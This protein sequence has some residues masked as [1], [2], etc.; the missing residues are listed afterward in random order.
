MTYKATSVS[1]WDTV[2]QC[3]PNIKVLACAT[4]P[5][6]TTS[7]TQLSASIHVI[8]INESEPHILRKQNLSTGGHRIDGRVIGTYPRSI[9][10]AI[11]WAEHKVIAFRCRGVNK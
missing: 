4:I 10:S 5:I 2:N 9:V 1:C 11:Y 8:L 3:T 7:V 6:R